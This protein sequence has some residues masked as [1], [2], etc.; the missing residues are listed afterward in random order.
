MNHNITEPISFAYE[1]TTPE[2]KGSAPL[3][4]GSFRVYATATDHGPQPDGEDQYSAVVTMISWGGDPVT[5][6]LKAL[7]LT[8]DSSMF[9]DIEDRAQLVAKE[10][11]ESQ[12]RK[13]AVMA[14]V[15][16]D[17]EMP[18]LDI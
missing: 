11:Y 1:I 3:Y 12:D 2:R 14:H 8:G 15:D 5:N 13:D 7:E 6:V 17:V 16:R 10:H 18:T 9:R 4:L